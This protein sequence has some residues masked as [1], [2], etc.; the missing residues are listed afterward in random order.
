VTIKGDVAYLPTGEGGPK[1][2]FARRVGDGWKVDFTADPGLRWVMR[3]SIACARWQDAV[4]AM[5]LPT[6]TREGVITHMQAEADA[7]ASFLRGPT[8]TRRRARRRWRRG[9]SPD[10]SI[11]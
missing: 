11:G 8:P 3:T 1:R 4:Q 10:R 5:A 7:L 6:A 9:S 2:A